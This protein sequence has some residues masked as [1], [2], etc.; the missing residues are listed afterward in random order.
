MSQLEKSLR[1]HYHSGHSNLVSG[2]VYQDIRVMWP[3]FDA[4]YRCLLQLPR[5]ACIVELG[6]GSGSLVAWLMDKGFANVTGVDVSAQEVE[7]ARARGIPLVRAEAHDYLAALEP[8]SVQAV[9]SKAMFEHM[10]RQDGANLLQA[11]ARALDPERGLIVI[12]IPNMDWL[13]ASHERYMDVTHHMGYTRESIRQMC[14]MYFDAVD[15]QG[16]VEPTPSIAAWI[17]VKCIKPL[18]VRCLRFVFR[19]MGEG[20]A[21]VLFDTRS[22]IAIGKL[23]G[24]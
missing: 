13:L 6:S 1:H 4:N 18:L 15:V 23:E 10:P 11:A 22:I 2:E 24:R 21:N 3:Y 9:V 20:A 14:H 12:D 7:A 17:R 16:S 5:D 19:I 8:G